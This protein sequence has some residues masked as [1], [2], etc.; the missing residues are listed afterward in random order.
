[1]L[2]AI[3]LGKVQ[4]RFVSFIWGIAGNGLDFVLRLAIL[5]CSVI[6]LFEDG[7]VEI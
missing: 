1:M 2:S 6:S 4:R 5:N 3:S 7:N